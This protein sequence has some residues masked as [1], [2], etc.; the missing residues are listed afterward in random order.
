M[1]T[2]A[3]AAIAWLSIIG[4]ATASAQEAAPSSPVSAS[5]Q[6]LAIVPSSCEKPSYPAESVRNNEQG[7]TTLRFLSDDEGKVVKVEVISTSGHERLDQAA[8]SALSKCRFRP[9][10]KDGKHFGGTSVVQYIWKVE[11]VFGR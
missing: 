3:V 2:S 10:N 6:T 8:V 4:L 9:T 11:S 5:A 7:T 1:K